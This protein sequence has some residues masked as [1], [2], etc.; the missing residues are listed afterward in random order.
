M[1]LEEEAI[2][3]RLS[4]EH[5]TH[6]RAERNLFD[7]ASW[8]KWWVAVVSALAPIAVALIVSPWCPAAWHW[9]ASIPPLIVVGLVSFATSRSYI[10]ESGWHYRYRVEL[11]GL[12]LA[13]DEGAPRAEVEAKRINLAR[14][15]GGAFPHRWVQSPSVS[16]PD[17]SASA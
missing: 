10:E 15:M 14:L 7:R 2:R 17:G 11:E 4:D 3:Q 5:A 6:A 8:V 16:K 9:A 1:P 13:L 12:Q